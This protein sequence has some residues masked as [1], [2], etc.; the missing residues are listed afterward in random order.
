MD[1]LTRVRR[2]T[3]RRTAAETGW[4]EA[5]RTAVRDGASLRTVGKAAGISNVM[6]LKITR[7]D[8]PS[9]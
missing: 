8:A 3:A 9:S 5:I 2:A 4:H 1:S 6:V 7:H